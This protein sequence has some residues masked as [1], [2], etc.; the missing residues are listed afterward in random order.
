MVPWPKLTGQGL[1]TWSKGQYIPLPKIWDENKPASLGWSLEQRRYKLR[2]RTVPRRLL[3]AKCTQKLRGGKWSRCGERQ[4]ETR[5]SNSPVLAPKAA[6]GFLSCSNRVLIN[7][8]LCL[9]LSEADSFTQNKV[10]TKTCKKHLFSPDPVIFHFQ[11]IN[12]IMYKYLCS[13]T[14]T[15]ELDVKQ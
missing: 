15:A 13:R 10:F 2:N 11:E 5:D 14:Y 4:R 12:K 6:P 9:S 1:D 8:P 7:S 3:S